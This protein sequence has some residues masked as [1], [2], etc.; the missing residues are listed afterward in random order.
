L[1]KAAAESPETKSEGALSVVSVPSI[2]GMCMAQ[3][4]IGS[5][6]LTESR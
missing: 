3:C 6:W 4:A 2:C 1:L 5:T